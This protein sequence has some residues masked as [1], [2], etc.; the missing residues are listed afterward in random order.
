M[1]WWCEWMRKLT[2]NHRGYDHRL[3][4]QSRFC[5]VIWMP[6]LLVADEKQ[7]GHIPLWNCWYHP[8]LGSR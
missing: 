3:F 1:P 4:H 7:S 6:L 5:L 2:V 8:R